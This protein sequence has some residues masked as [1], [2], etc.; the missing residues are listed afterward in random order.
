M[1]VTLCGLALRVVVYYYLQPL[2]NDGR[3]H[4]A[5]VEAIATRGVLPTSG[6]NSQSYQPPLYYIIASIYWKDGNAKRVQLLSL[7]LSIAT[8]L[9]YHRLLARTHLIRDARAKFWCLGLIAFLPQ[10]VMHSLYVSNDTLAMLIG[11][12]VALLISELAVGPSLPGVLTLG[13]VV[14]L[15]MLTKATFI[16]Y[17][18]PVLFYTS[19]IIR[20]NS[21]S[22]CKFISYLTLQISIMLLIGSY[23]Y[24]QNY[25]NYG[26]LLLCNLDFNF[27]WVREQIGTY[28][29][30]SS[31]LDV[32]VHK[33]VREPGYS[34]S[35]KHSY[36][37]LLYGTFWYQYILESNFQG[38]RSDALRPLG[39]LIYLLALAPTVL[40][41]WGVVLCFRDACRGGPNPSA[42]AGVLA[43]ALLLANLGLLF[44]AELR[45]DVWSIM[46]S[47]L[48]FPSAFGL[49]VPL[50]R[51]LE[52][53]GR[54]PL[55]R[56]AAEAILVLLNVLFL[57]Y[58]ECEIIVVS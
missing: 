36:N 18:L 31:F 51:G 48:V 58:F 17:T 10:F 21:I 33:L 14:G 56:A 3:D 40:A 11:A 43:I 20:N 23:K 35:T 12:M 38:S 49:L 16:V 52:G 53:A 37:L 6:W 46:Q 19:Y 25:E 13:V 2:N 57:V 47:R 29:G 9:V 22:T 50:A 39:S 8:L 7:E 54:W 15:G 24:V 1:L 27:P 55:G 42:V 28:Q 4:L 26:N 30:V 32:G 34:E 41:A 45:Y 44:A 5:Y